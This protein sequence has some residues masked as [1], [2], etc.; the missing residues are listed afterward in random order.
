MN[1]RDYLH[2]KKITVSDF[3]RQVGYDR[4]YLGDVVNSKKIP[5]KK[6]AKLINLKS[7]GEVKIEE[8]IPNVNKKKKKKVIE[9]F[10]FPLGE[11]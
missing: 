1:L 11:P 8:L 2:F 9:Q 5:G 3:A 7:N 10:E 6:L 4:S